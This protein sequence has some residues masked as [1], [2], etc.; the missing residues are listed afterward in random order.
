MA[1]QRKIAD[2]FTDGFN[3]LRLAKELRDKSIS[4]IYYV[5]RGDERIER[6]KTRLLIDQT[7]SKILYSGHR[8]SGK[9]TELYH[10][11]FE[12]QSQYF[13]TF[14]SIFDEL[15]VGDI[16]YIDIL[17]TNALKLYE[18][19][20]EQ[21]LPIEQD[22]ISDLNDWLTQNS[23]EVIKTTVE[24]K[25][26]GW[27]LGAKLKCLI[28]EFGVG[29]RSD[30]GSRNEIRQRLLPR[31][32]EVIK[33]SNLIAE[34][35]RQKSKKKPLVIIDDLDKL[36]TEPA[37]RIFYGHAQ[38]LIRPNFKI[39]Y[40]VPISLIHEPEFRQIETQFG[41]PD[42]LSMIKTRNK[43]GS[44]H[45]LGLDF[46]KRIISRRIDESLFEPEALDHLIKVSDGVLSDLLSIAETCCI[47]AIAQ[48]AP[49]ITWNMV[50][51]EYEMLTNTYRMSIPG[52]YYP[53]LAE[54]HQNKM[55]DN[56][57]K[58]RDLL[59]WLAALEYDQGRWHDVHPAVVPLLK[60]KDLVK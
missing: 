18:G 29:F 23:T 39:I 9:S 59:H 2:K 45:Q 19:A 24:Q 25:T 33:R 14:Y 60:E 38:S 16:D 55:T 30:A 50:D 37:K 58:L 35:I 48:G 49:R 28:V 27:D 42:V 52:E 3:N 10:L 6:L 12:L 22:L 56:D 34:S 43:D 13:I 51:E 7:P 44:P 11:M 54:I 53:K 47:K 26:K 8:R 41:R 1:K 31:T 4:D 40:T 5:P 15:E 36:D 46:L 17:V 57:E 32:S 21:G 20:V